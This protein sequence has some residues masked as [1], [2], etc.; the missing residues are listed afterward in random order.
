ML[1]AAWPLTCRFRPR[2]APF[3]LLG[4]AVPLP[5]RGHYISLASLSVSPCSPEV[6]MRGAPANKPGLPHLLKERSGQ[7][8]GAQAGVRDGTHPLPR[9]CQDAGIKKDASNSDL[10][11]AAQVGGLQDSASP[12]QQ[13]AQAGCKLPSLVGRT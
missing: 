7:I 2:P 3:G 12:G 9:V 1:L 8:L 4:A 10:M 5:P 11:R 13:L 6:G